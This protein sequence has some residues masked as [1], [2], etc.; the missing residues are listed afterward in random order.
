MK[1][2]DLSNSSIICLT[3]H[4]RFL[5]DKNIFFLTQKVLA[6][7]DFCTY[8]I[9]LYSDST[10]KRIADFQKPSD[11]QKSEPYLSNPKQKTLPTL[12]SISESNQSE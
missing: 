7:I 1:T 9:F 6:I 10:V 3:F 8:L 2:I 5:K 12:L 4:C 11:D